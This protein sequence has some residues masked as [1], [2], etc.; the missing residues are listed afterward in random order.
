MKS[1]TKLV[2]SIFASAWISSACTVKSTT[3]SG[4]GSQSGNSSNS[5]SSSDS[6][7]TTTTVDIEATGVASS[8]NSPGLT[9]LGVNI[10]GTQGTA[11][12]LQEAAGGELSITQDGVFYFPNDLSAGQEFAI[13]ELSVPKSI[14]CDLT[15]ATGQFE[16]ELIV[17]ITCIPIVNPATFS[18][19]RS[20]FVFLTNY[21][22]LEFSIPESSVATK[23]SYS[24]SPALPAGLS[25]DTLTGKISGQ[26]VG[27]SSETTY[28]VTQHR[29]D[30]STETA[31]IKITAAN[32]FYVDSEEDIGDASAGNGVCFATGATGPNQCTLRAA[33]EEANALAGEQLIVIN[34]TVVLPTATPLTITQDLIISGTNQATSVIDGNANSRIFL[35]TTPIKLTLNNLT[36]T[37]ATPPDASYGG[38]IRFVAAGT[39]YISQVTFDANNCGINQDG[40]GIHAD[41]L[42]DFFIEYVTFSN[43]VA[44]WD[45]GAWMDNSSGTFDHV[46]VKNNLATDIGAGISLTSGNYVVSNTV[47]ADNVGTNAAGAMNIGNTA[48]VLIKNSTFENNSVTSGSSHGGAI[49]AMGSSAVTIENSTFK[50]NSSADDAGA[51]VS[52]ETSTIDIY[53]SA[54]VDNSTVDWAG[55]IWTI[56]TSVS[57]IYNSYFANNTS[58]RSGGIVDHCNVFTGAGATTHHYYNVFDIADPGECILEPD[59]VGNTVVADFKLGNYGFNGGFVKSWLL[60]SD[61]PLIDAGSNSNCTSEDTYLATRPIDG[62]SNGSANCDI[63]PVEYSP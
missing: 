41:G 37:N 61:S 60:Q 27:S 26:P 20:S 52:M 33:V 23:A 63:G 28:I 8:G 21:D 47:F 55:A 29:Y 12:S 48:V 40:C 22:G 18:Y 3:C 49:R 43:T 53:N 9:K 13:Q 36:L 34:G 35:I 4:D 39:L 42:T 10:S 30:G 5:N 45:S 57:R 16:P 15:A 56:G 31:S 11:L 50:G 2:L 46:I 17:N 51:I 58:Q 14:F 44:A 62:D 6:N 25:L 54:F 19:E 32:G 59:S 1:V 7:C 38:A 24:V